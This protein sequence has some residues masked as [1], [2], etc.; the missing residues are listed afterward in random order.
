MRAAFLLSVVAAQLAC[1]EPLN[2][3]ADVSK[4]TQGVSFGSP[5]QPVKASF[6]FDSAELYIPRFINGT[7]GAN[8]TRNFTYGDL[9]QNSYADHPLFGEQKVVVNGFELQNFT[10]YDWDSDYIYVGLCLTYHPWTLEDDP[11]YTIFS[12]IDSLKDSGYIKSRSFSVFYNTSAPEL[13][14]N[15]VLLGAID[16]GKY[17][18]PLV[19][20]K[21]YTNETVAAELFNIHPTLAMDGMAGYNFLVSDQIVTLITDD[22]WYLPPEYIAALDTYFQDRYGF[23][24][25]N[26]SCLI[27]DLTEYIS[28][29]FSG[30]EYRMLDSGFFSSYVENGTTFCYFPGGTINSIPFTFEI[31]RKIFS[32]HYLVV[33]YDH[34]E[35]GIAQAATK[36]NPPTIEELSTGIPLATPAKYYSYTSLDETVVILSDSEFYLTTS[37]NPSN[38]SMYTGER[39]GWSATEEFYLSHTSSSTPSNSVTLVKP[40]ASST[41]GNS[42]KA[43]SSSKGVGALK[44]ASALTFIGCI[45]GALM[46]F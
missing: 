10:F 2:E 30:V 32:H 21:L 11:D 8:I 18:G 14:A 19:K 22:T 34:E 25:T 4:Q 3:R 17:E 28:F 13:E 41:A 33:D 20:H 24:L 44:G 42:T 5:P 40:T 37:I 43:S 1:A 39:L 7:N 12:T 26:V 23:N 35:I 27:M 31:S 6:G 15:E 9:D 36:S 46:M 29:Y 45:L 16:H 38:Y